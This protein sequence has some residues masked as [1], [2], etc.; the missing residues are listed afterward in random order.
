VQGSP[1]HEGFC[2]NPRA[3]VVVNDERLLDSIKLTSDAH[4][5]GKLDALRELERLLEDL[6]QDV[7]ERIAEIQAE[8]DGDD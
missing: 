2:G 8:R 3:F 6:M 1:C 5:K 7:R 4:G